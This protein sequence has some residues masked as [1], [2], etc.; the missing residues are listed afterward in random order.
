MTG[1]LFSFGD[2]VLAWNSQQLKE[3]A[4]ELL[5]AVQFTGKRC[6][7]SCRRGTNFGLSM[8]WCSLK[9]H[10]LEVL[11]FALNSHTFTLCL[12]LLLMF[13]YSPGF[14]ETHLLFGYL[15]IHKSRWKNLSLPFLP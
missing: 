6:Q 2:L 7:H 8:G 10:V 15:M 9:S 13:M 14:E 5:Q 12:F 3:K 11:L 1:F 4:P